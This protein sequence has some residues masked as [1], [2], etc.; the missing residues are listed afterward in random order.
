MKAVFT[1]LIISLTC[2][3]GAHGE[4]YRYQD[5]NGKWRYS[6]KPPAEGIKSDTLNIKEKNP[7]SE[8]DGGEGEDLAA[9]LN[10]KMKPR[11]DIEKASVAVVKVETSAG[12]GTGFFVT[13][14]GYI[15]TN[16]HVVRPGMIESIR[17][18]ENQIEE[19]VKRAK[20]Y[21]DDQKQ[22]LDKYEQDI[23]DYGQKMDGYSPEDQARMKEEYSYHSDRYDLLK[24]D[25]NKA[26]AEYDKALKALN[27]RKRGM[28]LSG[29][30]NNFKITFKDGATTKQATL[31]K[32]SSNHD[33]ALL[34][35]SGDY[36]TPMLSLG[37]RHDVP[38]G[39]KVYAI[40]NPLGISDSVTS[41]ILTRNTAEQIFT[42]AKIYPGNSG[43][44]LMTP[45]GRVIGVN[46]QVLRGGQSIG[47]E[48]FG[49][50]IPV[51]VVKEEFGSYLASE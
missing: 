32:L 23:D 22:R 14:T 15:V 31:I 18:E 4:I 27:D 6:D 47:T 7:I 21:L 49:I 43:G 12:L 26:K 40:G 17:D 41:G 8:D 30:A 16:K 25:Y 46:T 36:T 39:G 48:I 28:N 3:M 13:A 34:K 33:L 35:L 11:T 9:Y 19:N 50:A 10:E 2:A 20:S 29:S 44:P 5:E 38:Q 42:D 37:S 51:E 24:K 45:E 1:L